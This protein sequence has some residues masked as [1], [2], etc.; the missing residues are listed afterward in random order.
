[1]V[2][3]NAH[4]YIRLDREAIYTSFTC[5]TWPACLTFL[6]LSV[7][8]ELFTDIWALSCRLE[9]YV[10]DLSATG[11][12]KNTLFRDYMRTDTSKSKG[13]CHHMTP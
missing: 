8:L 3:P 10:R 4:T 5:L 9:T 11:T 7:R 13:F 6:Y 2:H 1:M 12:I